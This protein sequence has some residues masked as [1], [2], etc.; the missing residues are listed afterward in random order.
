MRYILPIALL[1]SA[2]VVAQT[3]I[4]DLLKDLLP[5]CV[6]SCA[7]GVL[8]TASSCSLDDTQCMCTSDVTTYNLLDRTA[9][10]NPSLSET[11]AV[12]SCGFIPAI[13]VPADVG[14][15]FDARD[16]NGAAA[17]RI[18]ET[19]AVAIDDQRG[20][21][22]ICAALQ[23]NAFCFFSMREGAVELLN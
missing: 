17:L 5:E 7:A 12:A 21:E 15:L 9:T 8:E 1:S 19:E 18:A 16:E 13:K 10:P 20:G 14:F 22:L 23:S 4:Q 2:T 6:H 3:S 11:H